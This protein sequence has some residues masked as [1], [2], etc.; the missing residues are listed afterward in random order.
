MTTI[1]F[2]PE[3]NLVADRLEK[4]LSAEKVYLFGSYA[5]GDA[6]EDSDL[7]FL[8]VV[9]DSSLSRYERAVHARSL[10]GN[11]LLPLDILVLTKREWE[12]EKRVVCSL[13]STVLREGICLHG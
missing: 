12:S 9:P 3:V 6:D 5:R 4:G 7:D 11:V 10:V 1:T 13:S 2:P 8:V